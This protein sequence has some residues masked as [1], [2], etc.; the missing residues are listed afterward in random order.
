MNGD[1]TIIFWVTISEGSTISLSKPLVKAKS[2]LNL[3]SATGHIVGDSFNP[4]S[5]PFIS[6]TNSLKALSKVCSDLGAVFENFV[7]NH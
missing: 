3:I 7:G 1:G 4:K 5:I 2:H 6:T